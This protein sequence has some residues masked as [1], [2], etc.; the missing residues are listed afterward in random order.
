MREVTKAQASEALQ[1]VGVKTGDGLLVHSAIHFLG[2]PV[3]GPQ[4]YFEAIM[5]VIGEQG[6]LCV[7]TFNFAFTKSQVYDPQQTPSAGMGVFSEIIRQ[8]PEA[9]RTTHPMQSL[10]VIGKYRDDLT[11]RDTPCAFDDDSAFDRMLQL[12]FKL[13]LLGADIQAV[14]LIHY[15]EQRADVPYRHWKDFTGPVIVNGRTETRT[16]RMFAR[17]MD[18]DA[19]LEIYPIADLM[20]QRGQWRETALNYGKIS[21]CRLRD[22]VSTADEFFARDPWIFVTNRPEN[23]GK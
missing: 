2:R 20:R 18:V 6:T 16:Y 22:F 5:E 12:N 11:S 8:L 1:A 23:A 10:A 21:T 14:A 7:P 13:L 4:L 9:R 15:S 17:D 19:R 3:G